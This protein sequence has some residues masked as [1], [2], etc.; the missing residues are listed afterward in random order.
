MIYNNIMNTKFD[1]PTQFTTK[2]K[3]LNN[4]ASACANAQ[5]DDFKV[6]W[7][8]KLIDLAKEYKMLD[9]VMKKVIRVH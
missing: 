6:L 3:R 5:S 8:N 9:Y 7:Y 2:V 1:R 4:L